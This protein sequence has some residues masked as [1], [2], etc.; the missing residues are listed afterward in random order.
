LNVSQSAPY[1]VRSRGTFTY[2]VY[3]NAANIQNITDTI[4]I[5]DIVPSVFRIDGYSSPSGT[6]TSTGQAVYWS[7]DTPG[8]G[9]LSASMVITVTVREDQA[10]QSYSLQTNTV[11]A[12]APTC[13]ECGLLSSNSSSQTYIEDVDIALIGVKNVTGDREIC[14]ST[15]FLYENDFYVNLPVGMQSLV[16][17]E[18][19]GTATGFSGL[20]A[21]LIYQTGT[22]SVTFNG[23]DVTHLVTIEQETPDLVVNLNRLIDM[24]ADIEI[25]KTSIPA[26]VNAGDL[27]TYTL[28]ATNQSAF[29]ATNVV[30]SDTLPEG[31]IGVAVDAGDFDSCD[32]TIVCTLSELAPNASATLTVTATVATSQAADLINVAYVTHD[33]LDNV[34]ERNHVVVRTTV[35][36]TTPL[37]ATDLQ[38][39]K[40]GAPAIVNAGEAVAYTMVV[41]NLGAYTASNVMVFDALPVSFSLG[42]AAASQGSCSGAHPLRCDL[43]ELAVN[44]TATITVVATADAPVTTDAMNMAHV[45]ADNPDNDL[46]NNAATAVTRVIRRLPLRIQYRV[47]APGEALG[48]DVS[49]TWH[50]WSLLY[51]DAIGAGSCR[52][53]NTLYMGTPT[54][55]YRS[56]LGIHI[57]TDTPNACE[58]ELVT[59]NVTGGSTNALA[60]NLVVTMTL[61]AND[62]YT[63]AGYG[64]F[65]A[66]NPPSAVISNGNQITWTWDA[67]LPITANG[68]IYVEVLRPCAATGPLTAQT[69][70]QDRCEAPHSASAANSFV[71]TKPNLYL[72]LTPAQY[73]IVDKTAV[74]TVYVINTGDGDAVNALIT[75]TLGSGLAFSRSVVTGPSGVITTTGVGDGNDVQWRAP[76]L[77]VGQ[78]IRID[79][80]ADVIAC[81]GLTMQAFADA[82]CQGGTCSA[83]GPQ[84]ISLLRAPAALL[85]SNRQVAVLP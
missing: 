54:T 14:G 76:R 21:P 57:S 59:L 77:S 80:Y 43:G 31:L 55:I 73:E 11:N 82:S 27:L 85:S 65:F 29:T 6:I 83:V 37:T 44:A 2:V 24:A 70:F 68:S 34:L 22:L 49:R 84:S 18:T 32:S 52:G 1:A 40:I 79:V 58:P 39:S 5:T 71:P 78:Q 12:T 45:V 60:D 28:T 48:G 47:I 50:D 9:S 10:C 62:V 23:I 64:G 74:W 75:N 33:G 26:A 42:S 35:T 13:P 4:L 20:A 16:F 30:V 69:S 61:G 72:F 66:A 25:T 36:P 63:V 51:I 81:G 7:V 3:L 19:L 67:A 53:N 15:G 17:T 56:N 46:A 8:S 38:I 41:T